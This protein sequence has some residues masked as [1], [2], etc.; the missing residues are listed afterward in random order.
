MEH[1]FVDHDY[2]VA[3]AAVSVAAPLIAEGSPVDAGVD[4]VLVAALDALTF[5]VLIIS[6]TVVLRRHW[7]I[8]LSITIA[9]L[10]L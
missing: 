7:S 8:I 9:W 5:A 4:F 1:H 2:L 10:L 6:W 3:A